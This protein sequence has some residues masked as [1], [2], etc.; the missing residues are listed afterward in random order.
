M[1]EY[2]E[3]FISFDRRL[4]SLCDVIEYL[5]VIIWYFF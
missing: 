3:R 1:E 4:I 2:L 5:R